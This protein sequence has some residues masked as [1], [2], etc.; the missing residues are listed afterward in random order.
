MALSTL[1]VSRVVTDVI[2]QTLMF[3]FPIWFFVCSIF[4]ASSPKNKFHCCS[5]GL[6]FPCLLPTESTRY[7]LRMCELLLM[8]TKVSD[9]C[10]ITT[11]SIA[12]TLNWFKLNM[13]C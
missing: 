8:L 12:P 4:F 3:F 11:L 7:V 2:G 5:H 13:L 10:T 1:F 6:N 9:K